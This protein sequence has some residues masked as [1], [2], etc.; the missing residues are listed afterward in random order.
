MIVRMTGQLYLY[1][2]PLS[3]LAFLFHSIS[4]LLTESSPLQTEFSPCQLVEFDTIL[5]RDLR[6]F[7]RA[8]AVRRSRGNCYGS[9]AAA[10]EADLF[11]SLPPLLLLF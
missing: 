11:Q 6:R 4:L 10:L 5:H 2:Y 9:D 1:H 7:S 8:A 3:L